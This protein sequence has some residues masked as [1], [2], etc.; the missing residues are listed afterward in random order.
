M[1]Y[2]LLG[3]SLPFSPYSSVTP[4]SPSPSLCLSLSV[5]NS[6]VLV[7]LRR[8]HL[9]TW[10]IALVINLDRVISIVSNQIVY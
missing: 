7:V 3:I 5:Y 9:P 6:K 10:K 4:L 8:L 2:F 1:Q